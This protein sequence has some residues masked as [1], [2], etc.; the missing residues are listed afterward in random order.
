MGWSII[1][2][3]IFEGGPIDLKKNLN[4]SNV[5]AFYRDGSTHLNL[6]SFHND[7]REVAS[8]RLVGKI[9]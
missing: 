9:G 4:A 1:R 2:N 6:P 3:T 8:K 7:T 5:D